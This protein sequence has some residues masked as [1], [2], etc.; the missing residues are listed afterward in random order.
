MITTTPPIGQSEGRLI[1]NTSL[2]HLVDYH[3]EIQHSLHRGAC[4]YSALCLPPQDAA[5]HAM[6]RLPSILPWFD[7]AVVYNVIHDGAVVI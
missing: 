1:S 2:H 3:L 6:F 7:N 5:W 4:P